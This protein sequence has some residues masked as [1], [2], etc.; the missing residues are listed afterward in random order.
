MYYVLGGI[1]LLGF[2]GCLRM[3]IRDVKRQTDSIFFALFIG[4]IP[5]ANLGGIICYI[6][7]GL[8]SEDIRFLIA[9]F[10]RK[11]SDFLKEKFTHTIPGNL[12]VMEYTGKNP[13]E[14]IKMKQLVKRVEAVPTKILLA[15]TTKKV[16]YKLSNDTEVVDKFEIT[17][18][19][20][21]PEYISNADGDLLYHLNNDVECNYYLSKLELGS[22]FKNTCKQI[23]NID[24]K[25]I[26]NEMKFY[27]RDFIG[28]NGEYFRVMSFKI[29]TE[30][31]EVEIEY[32]NYRVIAKEIDVEIHPYGGMR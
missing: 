8:F 23:I 17:L 16:T 7:D 30:V 1:Y 32:N 20:V 29:E 4:I 22:I 14:R 10:D 19:N 9:N 2:L 28:E 11:P 21:T 27:K 12:S 18:P 6:M 24:E 3:G 25:S 26:D 5:V 13:P 15:V 31:E